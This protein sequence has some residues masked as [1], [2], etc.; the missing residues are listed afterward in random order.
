[1]VM[2]GKQPL[3]RVRGD[4][5]AERPNLRNSRC[6]CVL[7]LGKTPDAMIRTIRPLGIFLVL[8]LSFAGGGT[9]A[10]ARTDQTQSV[11]ST[12]R[13][14]PGAHPT[15]SPE[16]AAHPHI[17]V[18]QHVV[19]H[20]SLPV[21]SHHVQPATVAKVK[22]PARARRALAQAR[23]ERVEALEGRTR[24]P[25]RVV[26]ITPARVIVRM[27]N[28]SLRRYIAFRTAVPDRDRITVAAGN[29]VERTFQ[30]V[31][32][33][34]FENR[35][36]VVTR[37]LEVER[38]PEVSFVRGLADAD[39]EVMLVEPNQV[40][41]PFAVTTFQPLPNGEVALVADDQIP[42]TVVPANITF[43]GRVQSEVGNMVTFGLPN[44]TTRTLLDPGPLPAIGSIM[45]VVED[46]GQVLSLAP[47]VTNFLGQVV[48]AGNGFVTFEL[49]NGATRTLLVP[50]PAPLPGTRVVVYEDGAKVTRLQVL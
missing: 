25:A 50:S 9:S 26:A 38:T 27:P 10:A 41:V 37:E 6:L 29:G 14:E 23:E 42:A 31:R 19:R 15:R 45:N 1:M 24:V 48:A 46:G 36:V 3:S 43:V 8:C 11:Q 30:V 28:G 34:R 7:I 47:A 32:V 18:Q 40:P 13:H 20:V 44:G 39:D 21:A 49:P 35:V 12:H 5:A 17:D 16:K 33:S 22:H 4:T 2:H